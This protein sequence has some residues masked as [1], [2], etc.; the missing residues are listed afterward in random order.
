MVEKKLFAAADLRARQIKE[1]DH[2][3]GNINIIICGDFSQIKPVKGYSLFSKQLKTDNT[4][5]KHGKFLYEK[6]KDCI[7]FDEIKRQEQIK[8]DRNIHSE[9]EFLMH[10]DQLE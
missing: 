1:N 5:H 8:P 4:M 9:D 10:Q 3:W 2:F 6:F 7:V